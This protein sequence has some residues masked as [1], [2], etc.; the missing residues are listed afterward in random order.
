M[1]WTNTSFHICL[2][3]LDYLEVSVVYLDHID[4]VQAEVWDV[5]NVGKNRMWD[6]LVRVRGTGGVGI[7]ECM[8]GD[9]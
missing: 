5:K 1:S 3:D 6:D 8:G 9:V 2:P 4:D 7:S